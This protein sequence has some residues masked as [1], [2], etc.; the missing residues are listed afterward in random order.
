VSAATARPYARALLEASGG[1]A[2][3]VADELD[4]F[5]RVRDEAPAEW[6]QLVAPGIP[7]AARKATIDRFLAE[8]TPL[9]RNVLKVLVDNGRLEEA[10][11][12]AS[13]FR[14][15][16]KAQENQLDVHVTSAVELG[17]DLR[18]KLEQR[19]G[20]STGKRVRLH[21]SVDP[22]II[23]GLVV[24]HGDTLVDTSLRGRLD[25]L[26]LALSRPAPRPATPDSS[27]S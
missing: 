1:D 22:S 24:R 21:A 20:T 12:V 18:A 4:A 7:A 27:A 3:R 8:A 23:G 15:L 19:L 13:A 17:S 5:A 26:R 16:V 10:P 2:A 14:A 11:E 6:E 9:V 25:Q